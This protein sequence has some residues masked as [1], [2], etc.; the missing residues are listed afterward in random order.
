MSGIVRKVLR[1]YHCH[2]NYLLLDMSY[3]MTNENMTDKTGAVFALI[4]NGRMLV[5]APNVEK[6]RIP[7]DVYRIDVDAFSECAK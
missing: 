3:F 6:Y 1:N 7:E 2:C 4:D 5:K